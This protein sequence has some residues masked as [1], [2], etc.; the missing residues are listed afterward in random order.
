MFFN[1]L[2]RN[3][4][5]LLNINGYDLAY[6][7]PPLKGNI[8]RYRCRK[9]GCQYFIKIDKTNID[10]LQAKE[11]GVIYTEINQHK[12][13]K[14]L[15]TNFIS[16]NIKLEIE[17]DKLAKKLIQQNLTEPF[18]FQVDNLKNN[19]INWNKGKIRR[20]LYSMREESF[21][22]DDEFLKSIDKITINFS[23]NKKDEQVFCVSKGEF[24]NITKNRKLERYVI[25][26]SEFQINLFGEIDT[27]Y[28]DSTFKI[29]PKNWFQLLNLFGYIKKKDIYISL[30]FILMSSKTEQLY[31]EVFEQFKRIISGHN[32]KNTLYNI[33]I[34]C[35]F[36]FFL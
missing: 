13:K 36:L 19:K 27:L 31:I 11:T 34:I 26:F 14:E 35:N 30:G 8:Y 10:K 28:L 2:L 4:P 18:D 6:K 7:D 25:F 12:H 3:V 22:K 33:N 32:K 21:P 24:I 9:A 15:I 17:C 23:N 16:D 20:L 29:C 5:R 1:G